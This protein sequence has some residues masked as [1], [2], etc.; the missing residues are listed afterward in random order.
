MR[1]WLSRALVVCGVFIIVWFAMIVY[2]QSSNR[3]PTSSDLA[4]NLFA[5]PLGLLAALWLIIK[6]A[7]LFT[8]KPA[9]SITPST[10]QD[11]EAL[12]QAQTAEQERG[13]T[14]TIL[15]SAVWAVHG[16]SADEL[17]T[18]LSSNKATLDLDDE[19]KDAKDLPI[20]SGRIKEVDEGAQH[21]A[22]EKWLAA[23]RLP[24]A[25]PPAITTPVITWNSEQLRALAL[26]SEVVTE[27]AKHAI[28]H[29][30]LEEYQAAAPSKR[31]TVALP[32]L[33]L[34]A[35]L[36]PQWE[37]ENCKL[38]SQWFAH[39]IEQQGWPD[40]KIDLKSAPPLKSM[41]P[42]HKIDQLSVTSHRQA[43]PFFGIVFACE[44]HIGEHTVQAWENAGILFPGKDGRGKIPGEGA[45]GLLLA[46]AQQTRIMKPESATNIH[47][48][49]HGQRD[50][51]ADDS[52]R[53]GAELLSALSKDALLA[54]ST[55][56]EKITLV[57]ADTDQ[58]ASRVTELMAMCHSTFPDLEMSKQCLK[59]S[60]ACGT[61][62]AVSSL[63]AL[64]LAHHEAL[65][66]SGF[67][68]CIN[69]QDSLAR[70]AVMVSPYKPDTAAPPITLT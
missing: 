15:S 67:A 26:G 14:L 63:T 18:A 7:T 16:A 69:N 4:I 68:L 64:T 28:T 31:S 48:L 47:R 10:A 22:L 20:L 54:A 35:V 11:K 43:L 53:I 34:L 45:A 12:A 25:T 8:A 55:S 9:A 36:P 30:L 3:M 21:D 65:K 49:A 44:S 37:A 24:E 19:L 58:R 40:E 5:F 42:L 56:P 39:L 52:G 59:V 23:R 29:P 6:G 57:T 66:N 51:S 50:K 27:L 2:W 46:D 1:P 41:S 33:Q 70:A 60:A 32:A 17:T 13:L 62:G 38:A 61:A